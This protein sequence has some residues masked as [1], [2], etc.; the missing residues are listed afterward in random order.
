MK[1][2]ETGTPSVAVSRFHNYIKFVLLSI[3][4]HL[5]HLKFKDTE[6]LLN[7]EDLDDVIAKMRIMIDTADERYE[8]V[9]A[10]SKNVE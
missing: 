2:T 10:K 1:I 9:K 5:G 7:R 3:V 4:G 8:T 6:G